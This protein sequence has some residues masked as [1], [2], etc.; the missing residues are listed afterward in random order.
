M[1]TWNRIDE[2]D[3]K[4]WTEWQWPKISMRMKKFYKK[5]GRKLQFDAKEPVGFDK[6]KLNATIAIRQGILLESVESREIKT[7]EGGRW[8]SG[9]KDRSRTGQKEDSKALVT[10]DG[11][12]VD[13]TNHSKD[14]DYALMACNM[15]RGSRTQRNSCFNISIKESIDLDDKTDVLT[16]HKKLLA[17]A[18]KEKEDLKA[19]VEKWHNSSKNLSKL[20][21]TQMSAYDKFGLGYGDHRYDGIL[22]YENEVLQSVF[23]NKES[24]LEKQPLYDR[25]ENQANNHAGPQEATN[26]ADAKRTCSSEEEQVFLDE[27][28]RLK[29]QEKEANEE[30]EALRKKFAQD[31]KNLVIQAG[32]AKDSSTNIF[33][34]VNTPAKASSTN[35]VNTVSTPISTGS[36]HEGL[37]LSDPTNPEQ[38]DSEIPPLEDIYQNLSDCL[39]LLYIHLN[40]DECEYYLILRDHHWAVQ[41]RCKVG[42]NV[43]EMKPR[44]FQALKNKKLVVAM[45]RLLQFRYRSMVLV[46]SLHS[47]PIKCC[48]REFLA[49]LIGNPQQEVVNFLAGD[50]F[51]GNAKSKPLW[52]LLLWR[53]NMLLL[54]AA[55]GKF[56]GFK[57]KC[58]RGFRE[59]LRRVIDGTEALLLP[60]LFILW[61][62]TICTDSANSLRNLSLLHSYIQALI[63]LLTTITL[64]T[65]MAV[66]DSCPKHNMVAYLEKTEGNAEFH[67]IID[68][69]T[70]SSIH[71]ALTVSPVV[72]TTFVEQFW[73]SAKSKIINN[74][75]HITAKVAG[76]PVS[77]SE[78]S[79]RS[80]LLF[81]MQMNRHHYLISHHTSDLPAE[82]QLDSSPAHTGEKR[83]V[84]ILEVSDQQGNYKHLKAQ[85]KKLK[86]QAK[87]VIK[88]HR[89]WM[90]SV[91]LKQRLARK[92]SS[93]KPWVHKESVSKQGM[94]FAKGEPLVHKDPLFDHIPEDTL[95]PMET[96]NAQ[97]VGR[98][99]DI[100][101]EVRGN[102]VKIYLSSEGFY[103]STDKEKVS[104]DRPIVST[105]GS[106]VST[107]GQFGGVPMAELKY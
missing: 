102:C 70:R 30:A 91:S 82:P 61:L 26:N 9:T 12:G 6:T 52:L 93:K 15:L 107:D 24:E 97:V 3:L 77:I 47:P 58:L 79:I 48:H 53:Q 94:K 55:V 85:I 32:A 5:T 106:K 62:D 88:H 4:K 67:E 57:I 34:A 56:C 103:S 31:T 95:D 45:R 2:Y 105:D 64:T 96:E 68:F 76:K 87:P 40:D 38:D 50:S 13:W 33:S 35:L 65:T 84:G 92:R 44:R 86:K 83:L 18:Q 101:G 1:R 42:I 99:R 100:V 66:L 10:I 7:Q 16:Y 78:A 89:A 29:R 11:E 37:S 21:N 14:E 81:M 27:L 80:D 98:T 69:L 60:T 22:S 28:E 46:R 49:N 90:H 59:S 75:R 41:T 104:T 74:V 39:F 36:S 51:L 20:L 43:L 54:Q 19:K 72:S 17:E 8:N 25:S 73:T 63:S 71:H 23:M